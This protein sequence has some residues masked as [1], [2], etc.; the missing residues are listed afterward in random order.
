[1]RHLIG[2]FLFALM[3]LGI[4]PEPAAPA[5]VDTIV[6]AAV[7]NDPLVPWRP[8]IVITDTGHAIGFRTLF[9]DKGPCDA[10]LKTKEFKAKYAEAVTLMTAHG[11][12]VEPAKCAQVQP[13]S[14]PPETI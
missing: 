10:F 12:K 5:S 3:S 14:P 7:T 6:T 4:L 2:P 11:L 8:V 1:M 9:P 13:A